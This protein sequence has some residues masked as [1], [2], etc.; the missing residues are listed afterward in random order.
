MTRT[1]RL[2]IICGNLLLIFHVHGMLAPA[3]IGLT[4]FNATLLGQQLRTP[5]FQ[6][7]TPPHENS[8]QS[9]R[10]FLN[11]KKWGQYGITCAAAGIAATYG[12]LR[13]ARQNDDIHYETLTPEMAQ[14]ILAKHQENVSLQFLKDLHNTIEP[15]STPLTPVWPVDETQMPSKWDFLHTDA[16]QKHIAQK[17]I[18][19]LLQP[20]EK[21]NHH[22]VYWSVQA[23]IKN[24]PAAKKGLE[25][26]FISKRFDHNNMQHIARVIL[27]TKL[28]G[29]VPPLKPLD[30]KESPTVSHIMHH[31]AALSHDESLHPL[32]FKTRNCRMIDQ[33]I[34][35]E[36]AFNK[37]G[38]YTFLHG[39]SGL[40]G[41]FINWYT[42]LLQIKENTAFDQFVFPHCRPL[43]KTRGGIAEATQHLLLLREGRKLA[44]NKKRKADITL[45]DLIFVNN[46]FFANLGDQGSSSAYYFW[47]STNDNEQ[48][49]KL[50]KIFK[51]LELEDYYQAHSQDLDKSYEKIKELLDSGYRATGQGNI[52]LI[53][54][55]KALIK[56]AAFF[57]EPGGYKTMVN[58]EGIGLTDDPHIIAQT[59]R[60]HPEKIVPTERKHW[61]GT[62]N[63]DTIEAC[64]PT[65]SDF[66]HPRSGVK[67]NCFN[68]LN[69]A[70]RTQIRQLTESTFDKIRSDLQPYRKRPEDIRRFFDLI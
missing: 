36:I 55:P 70:K 15:K 33:I 40:C 28:W 49:C 20:S 29:T 63:A 56:E 35:A 45:R 47:F 24:H 30:K 50:Q 38:Y 3:H 21:I 53:A 43:Q 58:I 22:V 12:L 13:T 51:L 2:F 9:T 67:V 5:S 4:R 59:L 65:T 41:Q 17:I 52:I 11:W 1:N 31:L 44:P 7:N 18:N 26:F 19:I 64:I 14:Q 48:S 68:A 37:A 23:Q 25:D 66:M 10:P 57:A 62:T 16:M 39:Q 46:A 8:K 27:Y 60:D 34:K 69:K 32:I 54:I 61:R 6:K 42:Q